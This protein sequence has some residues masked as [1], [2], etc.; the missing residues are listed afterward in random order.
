[1]SLPLDSGSK[2]HVEEMLPV[3][4]V[5]EGAECHQRKAGLCVESGPMAHYKTQ[6][7]GLVDWVMV[8]PL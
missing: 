4:V 8:S 1:L 2:L 7:F 6:M 5:V 3:A